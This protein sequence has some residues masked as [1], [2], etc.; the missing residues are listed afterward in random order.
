MSRSLFNTRLSRLLLDEVAYTAYI[1][2][3]LLGVLEMGIL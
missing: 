2:Y 3:S 1:R